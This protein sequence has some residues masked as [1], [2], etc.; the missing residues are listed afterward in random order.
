MRK[1]DE[2]CVPECN[3]G[4]EFGPAQNHR[5]YSLAI[6]TGTFSCFRNEREIKTSTTYC[7]HNWLLWGLFFSQKNPVSAEVQNLNILDS[8]EFTASMRPQICPKHF[9]C[10]EIFLGS[11]FVDNYVKKWKIADHKREIAEQMQV[12][13]ITLLWTKTERSGFHWAEAVGATFSQPAVV[14]LT[15]LTSRPK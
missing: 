8:C 2:D 15:W 12:P 14:H 5:T 4:T 9:P 13:H 7:Q 11:H 1:E 6:R 3:L 10:P